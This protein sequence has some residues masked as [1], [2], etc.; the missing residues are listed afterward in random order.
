MNGSPSPPLA[1]TP[2]QLRAIAAR[3]HDLCVSAGAGSGKTFVLVER[4]V[5][6]VRDGL[7]PDE[8]LTITFTEK[9]AQ[10]MT[11]RIA[12]A[13]RREGLGAG[14]GAGRVEGAW[15][16]TIHG[17]CARLLRER[18][19]EA[20]VD[21]GFGVLTDVPAARLR[22]AAFLEAQ[23]RFRAERPGEYDAL[24]ERVRWGRDQDGAAGVHRLVLA[25][26]DEVRA[27]GAR[28][29]ELPDLPLTGLWL[30]GV[31]AS[32]ERLADAVHGFL[33]ACTT[34]R[35]TPR[36][37][38]QAEAVSRLSARVAAAPLQAFS[39]AVYHDLC[40]L[41]EAARG[42]GALA[43]ELARLREAAEAA[44]GAWAEGP[45]RALGRALHAL[46]RRFDAE[47]RRL[48]AGQAALDFSDLEE[49]T[50]DL[51]EQR[52]DVRDD[53]QRRFRAVL[54]DEFQDTSRLQQRLVDL[55]RRPQA[56]FVVG[57]VKQS[58]YGFRH[59]EVRG[60]LETERRVREGGGEVIDLD[61][62]F[63]TR[64]E[65]LG[66]VDEVFSRAWSEP[67]SEVPHLP[68]H[69][70]AEFLDKAH[71][72]LE[73]VCARGESLERARG[74]EARAVAARLAC[75][76]EERTLVSTHRGIPER[77]GRPLRY[78]DCAILVPAT[79]AL[80]FYERALR[81]RGVPY[82]VATG[83][84]FYGVREVVDAVLLL[85]VA[86]SP[87]DEL[88][89][90]AL[91]RSPAVGLADSTLLA[92]SGGGRQGALL[93]A[94]LDPRHA[95]ARGELVPGERARLAHARALVGELRELRGR[96]SVKEL[97]QRALRRT[98][99]QEGSLLREGDLRGWAN[100]EKLL[101][102]VEELEREGATGPGEV[103]AILTDLR[104]SGA[105]EPEANLASEG[106]D[107]VALLTVHAA[108]GL[109]WPLVVVADLGRGAPPLTDPILWGEEPGFVPDL[110]DPERPQATITAG[111]HRALREARRAREREESK[112][113][114]YVAM[115]RA[116]EHLILAGAEGERARRSGEWLRWARAPFPGR[117]VPE[118][119]EPDAP[120][121]GVAAWVRSAAGTLVRRL[122]VTGDV[123]GTR[124]TGPLGPEA[125]ARPV[126]DAPAR[127]ALARGQPAPLPVAPEL[128]AEAR[129]LLA[130]AQ[131]PALLAA[132]H[133][134]SHVTVS[135]VVTWF[136][137]PRRALLEYVVGAGDAAPPDE[138]FDGDDARQ[139]EPRAQARVPADVQG[140]LVHELLGR[141]LSGGARG[142]RRR[143]EQLLAPD[144]PGEDALEAAVDRALE[145]ARHF[146][147]SGLGQRVAAADEVLRELPFLVR[148]DLPGADPVLLRGTVDLLFREGGRWTLVDY[149]AGE[150]TA[151]EVPGRIEPHRLQLQLYALA[152]SLL[153]PPPAAA[154]LSYPAAGVDAWVE[155]G[156]MGRERAR[157]LLAEHALARRRLELPPRPGRHCRPCPHR[158][159]CPAG[160]RWMDTGQPTGVEAISTVG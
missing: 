99:L 21:P 124:I 130:R 8:I 142:V 74:L 104:L 155:V 41:A 132:D 54:V 115:T 111:S 137:C 66:F 52:P 40:A 103:A 25:L 45:A 117:A 149:K 26:Y 60:L 118:R 91:L 4:F 86:Q 58:I 126:L 43:H 90:A 79:T 15:I 146:E 11:E 77:L 108:K 23:R 136:G 36:L 51:L 29:P 35:R 78:G 7:G 98:G 122:D 1:A 61:R 55:V 145:L 50:R 67:G 144:L 76:V 82:R 20:G 138:P 102:V 80:R 69:A 139:D 47:F 112:R 65:V 48:K 42:A 158:S 127:A 89:L 57:D 28:L 13:L 33:S 14:N 143:L 106:E 75:L 12:R 110:R 141:S 38:R 73:L 39:P 148:V 71:P 53:L 6:L 147:R 62:S 97:L 64:P 68:L 30:P 131:A 81:E 95:A 59:A 129:E 159:T 85:A 150:M 107:A 2:A 5:G 46:L 105:R 140:T 154:A 27:A 96:V 10:E 83:R 16:S 109:E 94:L 32:F 31:Q 87:A 19:L 113:L 151:L 101:G 156:E 44:A 120:A 18:A 135:E 100:L 24:V 157:K 63:R 9:A 160:L 3:G 37:E 34:A 123:D 153:G 116:R 134:P 84:G 119:L 133:A 49:R 125:G 121:G 92:L 22:R 88:A 70:G 17:F 128:A 72:S 114:L 152:L 93:E 56:L